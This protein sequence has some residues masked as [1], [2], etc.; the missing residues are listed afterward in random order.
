MSF[1]PGEMFKPEKLTHDDQRLER[2]RKLI[3]STEKGNKY[4]KPMSGGGLISVSFDDLRWLLTNYDELLE[5]LYAKADEDM[6]QH[7]PDA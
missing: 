5:L 6:A 4:R 1:V 3:E 7:H 2:M